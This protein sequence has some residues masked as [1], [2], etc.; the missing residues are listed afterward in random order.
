MGRVYL[1]G[2]IHS[3]K[4]RYTMN[5][6]Q[7]AEEFQVPKST[8]HGRLTG[9]VKFG[10]I[11]GPQRYL[12]EEEE[13]ELVRFLFKCSSIGYAKSRKEVLAIV[14]KILLEKGIEKFV[15]NGWWES[16]RHRHP[17]V[18]LRS[19]E[20][21]SNARRAASNYQV[22]TKYFDELEETL[23]NNGLID[24]PTLLFN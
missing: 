24:N 7:A 20:K 23:R 12:T 11:G 22:L 8:L 9:K 10:C 2:G 6:R 17:E 14:Q 13:I 15:S 1:K 16:F 18:T 19:A 4:T 5:V 21:H 3:C